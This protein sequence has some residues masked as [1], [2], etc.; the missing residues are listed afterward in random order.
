MLLGCSRQPDATPSVPTPPPPPSPQRTEL[1]SAPEAEPESE[2]PSSQAPAVQSQL[3]VYDLKLERSALMRLEQTAFSN[4]TVPALFL[5]G[6]KQYEGVRVRYRGAWARS[7]P[8]KP[9]KVFFEPGKLFEGRRRLNLNSGWRDPA[10]VRE[11]LAYQLYAACGAVAPT[12]SMVRVHFN[13]RFRGL[14]VEVEQPDKA[15]LARLG[16][17]GA[18]VYKASSRANR[19]DE[20]DL[21]TEAAYRQHYEKETQEEDGYGELVAFC[22]ELAQT[23]DPAAFFKQHVDVAKYVNYLA[24]TV[25]CQNWDAFN[26][27]HFLLY[28]GKGSKKWFVI[29]W[30]LDRTFGDHWNWSFTEARLPALLGTREAPGITGWNRLQDRFLS[31][32]SLR[33]QFLDRLEELLEHEFT[34]EKLFPILDRLETEIG[35]DAAL[36]R[37]RWSSMGPPADLH[38]GIAQ[39]KRF[40]EQRRSFLLKEL[41]KLRR[42]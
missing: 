12:S 17:K 16:L 18:S 41:P 2:A 9:L 20:R 39:I 7:W 36:D 10:Y 21:G 40:I 15:F 32:P 11:H 37:Q 31:D 42:N 19:A 24:A 27:N 34:T 6:G 29:P 23:S 30:D 4:E 38:E 5:A 22:R 28:D 13:G 3:P 33:G 14:Y 35:P 1:A 8:K 26:K 25:L